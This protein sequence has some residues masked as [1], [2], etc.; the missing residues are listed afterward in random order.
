MIATLPFKD[1][2]FASTLL[3]HCVWNR[4]VPDGT[5]GQPPETCNGALFQR[6]D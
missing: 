4:N 5:P 2:F 6:D 1:R 3:L